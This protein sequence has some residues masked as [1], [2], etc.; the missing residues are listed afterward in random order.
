MTVERS[1]Q[2][3]LTELIDNLTIAQIREMLLPPEQDPGQAPA[4]VN[5]MQRLAHDL[6]LVMRAKRVKPSGRLLKLVMLLAQLNLMVWR[7]KDSMQ[8]QPQEYN[9]LLQRAQELNGVRNHIKNLLMKEF[10]EDEPSNTRATF[11]DFEGGKW[12]SGILK[13]LD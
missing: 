3:P 10:G 9:S 6:D 8:Q 13:S 12:Y 7:H 11:L 1:Y 4:A 2:F 5:D